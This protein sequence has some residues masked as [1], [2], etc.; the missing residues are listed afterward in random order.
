M[1]Q[2]ADKPRGGVIFYPREYKIADSIDDSYAVGVNQFNEPCIAYVRPTMVARE[3][4][5]RGA[6]AQTIPT[7][8]LFSETDRRA[9]N[10]CFSSSDNCPSSPDG[11]LLLEQVI[12][13]QSLS[14]LHGGLTVYVAQ[15]ASVL[16][17]ESSSPM[18]MI[19]P[20]YME[21]G[22]KNFMDDRLHDLAN[23]YKILSSAIVSGNVDSPIDA[24]TELQFIRRQILL[25]REKF[26]VCVLMACKQIRAY[27]QP[28]IQDLSKTI[29]QMLTHYTKNG[30]Y[31]SVLVRVR[32]NNTVI[33]KHCFTCTSSYDYTAKAVVPIEKTVSDFLRKNFGSI[34]AGSQLDGS[35]VELI[36][37][38]RINCGN[39]GRDKYSKQF[40]ALGVPKIIKTFIEKGYQE[41]PLCNYV[42]QNCFMFCNVA[43]RVSLVRNGRSGAG[44]ILLSTAHAFSPPLGNPFTV[45]NSGVSEY[46]LV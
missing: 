25:S 8:A 46:D 3:A 11:I 6:T 20:G 44:N 37:A 35:V 1:S 26:F 9:A 23:Q 33:R 16:R 24:D 38:Q 43:A 14:G 39:R 17:D 22:F 30:M 13:D 27:Q 21:I 18:P 5:S 45:N 12:V 15:W 7:I 31:S 34:R 4:A 36:P 29:T 19:A 42:Q 41:D 28:S 40:E 10:P 2:N 32:V